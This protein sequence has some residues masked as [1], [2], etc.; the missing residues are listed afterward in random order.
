MVTLSGSH[1]LFLWWSKSQCRMKI[2]YEFKLTRK[3]NEIFFCFKTQK[4]KNREMKQLWCCRPFKC[5]W[6]QYISNVARWIK[7][8]NLVCQLWNKDINKYIWQWN[9]IIKDEWQRYGTPQPF[10]KSA[11]RTNSGPQDLLMW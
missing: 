10:P 1:C 3:T 9:Q 6:I 5:A 7:V 2:L 8:N 4:P 11:P